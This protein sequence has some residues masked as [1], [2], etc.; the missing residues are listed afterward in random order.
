MHLNA[1]P[2]V[3]RLKGLVL[4]AKPAHSL[5]GLLTRPDGPGAVELVAG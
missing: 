2:Q 3:P 4:N 5:D 1:S